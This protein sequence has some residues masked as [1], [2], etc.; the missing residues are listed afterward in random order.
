MKVQV[1]QL[2]PNPFRN[3]GKYPIDREKVEA[4]KA[5]INE[6][7]FWDNILARKVGNKYQIAYGHH[8]LIALQEVGVKEVDIPVKDL[9]DAMMIKIM[10]NENMDQW[11]MNPGVV[12]ETVSTARDFL[13]AELKKCK[14]W[15][16]F[17]QVNTL[18]NLVSDK[19]NFEQLKQRGVGQITIL[20]FL[21]GC[22]KQHVIQDALSALDAVRDGIIAEETMEQIPTMKH[23]RVFTREVKKEKLTPRQQTHVAS[24][25]IKEGATAEDIPTLVMEEKWKP[26]PKDTTREKKHKEEV[27]S[28]AKLISETDDMVNALS[29]RIRE[30]LTVLNEAEDTILVSELKTSLFAI[31]VRRLHKDIQKLIDR[32]RNEDEN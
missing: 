32:T 20:K 8:R 3:I 11:K 10:A 15:E 6:T 17:K 7:E 31:N 5:S 22:W 14:S 26:E 2:E 19:S 30:I 28:F 1:K 18:I 27:L 9:T 12:M 13:D 16:E 23:V 29:N 4:L 24:R 25:I 21:G